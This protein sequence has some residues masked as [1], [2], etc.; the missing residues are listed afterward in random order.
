MPDAVCALLLGGL[1]VQ[2]HDRR[3]YALKV[4]MHKLYK[5]KRAASAQNIQ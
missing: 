2:L 1:Q 5:V 3:M 4:K